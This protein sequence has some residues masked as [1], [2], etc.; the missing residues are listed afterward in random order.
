MCVQCNEAE[1]GGAFRL[2]L[3]QMVTQM[4]GGLFNQNGKHQY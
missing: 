3:W 1:G 2:R 4:K